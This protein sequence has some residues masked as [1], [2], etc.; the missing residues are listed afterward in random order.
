MTTRT[1]A[2]T[3]AAA[4]GMPHEGVANRSVT[5]LR[6]LTIPIE[7]AVWTEVRA[8]LEDPT[9]L[10]AEY[11]R[12]VAAVHARGT[13][14]DGHASAA[15]LAK[16]RQGLARLI[17]SSTEGLLTQEEFEPRLGR[18]RQRITALEQQAQ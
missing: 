17:D 4:G 16:V 13:T 11:A 1:S 10:E 12:R 5:R 9:R 18:L 7:A 6:S 2:A 3:P 14:A 8:V 15:A